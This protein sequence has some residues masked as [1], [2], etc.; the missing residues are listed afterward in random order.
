[1][2]KTRVDLASAAQLAMHHEIAQLLIA[3]EPT[4]QPRNPTPCRTGS[5]GTPRERTSG[6]RR[7]RRCRH[8][9]SPLFAAPHRWRATAPRRRALLADAAAP[10][11]PRP[12]AGSRRTPPPKR[13]DSPDEMSGCACVG[14]SRPHR[15]RTGIVRQPLLLPEPV[16]SHDVPAPHQLDGEAR[17][18][19]TIPVVLKPGTRSIR[20]TSPPSASTRSCPTTASRR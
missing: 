9:A 16:A 20:T 2:R 15:E 18:L 10:P 8:A 7:S 6:S 1:M 17:D 11:P 3:T 5:A 19:R 13:R 12:P 14:P 4:P